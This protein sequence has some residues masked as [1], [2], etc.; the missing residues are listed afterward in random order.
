MSSASRRVTFGRAGRLSVPTSPGVGIQ[1]LKGLGYCRNMRTALFFLALTPLATAIVV[2]D[3]V[4]NDRAAVVDITI[5]TGESETR[6]G[7]NPA[8]LVYFTDG[9]LSIAVERPDLPLLRSSE[10]TLFLL[11]PE[12]RT[13]KNVGVSPLYFVR[14]AF[15]KAASLKPG[16]NRP[17]AELQ[18]ASGERIHTG[19][20]YPYRRHEGAVAHP[21]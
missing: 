1:D 13:V 7:G 15:L 21:S 19:V 11:S 2:T 9:S 17:F 6:M 8:A 3:A 4:R 10:V 12:E 16:H 14:I 20:R 18:T 5:E